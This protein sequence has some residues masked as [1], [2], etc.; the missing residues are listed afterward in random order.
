M[1]TH[2][3]S[4]GKHGDIFFGLYIFPFFHNFRL[5]LEIGGISNVPWPNSNF[6]PVHLNFKLILSQLFFTFCRAFGKVSIF[7]GSTFTNFDYNYWASNLLY[8]EMS[9]LSHQRMIFSYLML[10]S[11]KRNNIFCF[12]CNFE[13]KV[14]LLRRKW[15]NY[16]KSFTK[17]L[18]FS[19]WERI[20]EKG[21]IGNFSGHE[22]KC[23]CRETTLSNA[24]NHFEIF[25]IEYE[26][27]LFKE[28]GTR[29]KLLCNR[30]KI[31]EGFWSIRLLFSTTLINKKTFVDNVTYPENVQISLISRANSQTIFGYFRTFSKN[32]HKL[33]KS[34][35]MATKI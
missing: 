16:D 22:N 13:K 35:A 20:W 27:C 18:I 10:V 2:Q 9:L 14:Y 12:L 5:N 21:P 7:N 17:G 19:I 30:I 11:V 34:V 26:I 6:K 1:H 31:S 15:T 3:D 24:A 23:D 33:Q 29:P 32:D 28:P 4:G 25:L 8:H